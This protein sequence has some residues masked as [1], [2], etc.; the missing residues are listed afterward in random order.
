MLKSKKKIILVLVISTTL[1]SGCTLL[2]NAEENRPFDNFVDTV[3][4][5]RNR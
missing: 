2:N 1:T 5:E 4:D 3:L